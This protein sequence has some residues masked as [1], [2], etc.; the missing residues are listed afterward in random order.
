MVGAVV[1]KI[2][3]MVFNIYGMKKKL[4][5][6]VLGLMVFSYLLAPAIVYG[7]SSSTQSAIAEQLQAAAGD[8]GA[9]LGNPRDPRL[10]V[11]DVI[12]VVLEFLGI[13]FLA[14]TIYAGFLW[15][16]AGG[17]EER[18]TKSK[19]L[20][21]QAVIGLVIILAAY[22]ITLFAIKIATGHWTD[23]A[24]IQYIEQPTVT[25]CHGLSCP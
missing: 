4:F 5:F 21:F 13:I 25:E 2:S 24:N 15:M 7:V 14:L 19:S 23:Y 10:M 22:S 11:A 12:R 1:G 3:K 8:E 18:V 16:T 20:L 17:N 6:L 9:G